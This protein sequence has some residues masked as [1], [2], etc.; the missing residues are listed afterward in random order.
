MA[1]LNY[2]TTIDSLKTI[3]EI[4]AIL[5]K[6]GACSVSTEFSN[7]APVGIH[8]AIDLNGELLNF[9]LPSNA[10][11]V[12]QVPKKDTKVPNRYKT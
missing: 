8:F 11:E 2:T 10:E 6:H 3:G 9:K 12:Y 4:Q 1:I 7:G 5:A